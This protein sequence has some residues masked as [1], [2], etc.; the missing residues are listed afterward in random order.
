MLPAM[1]TRPARAAAFASLLLLSLLSC[2]GETARLPQST[3]ADREVLIP[4]PV[5]EAAP[6]PVAPDPAAP[7]PV[8]PDPAAPDPGFTGI[9]G[10]WNLKAAPYPIEASRVE[11]LARGIELID[12][13]VLVLTEIATHERIYDLIR[14]LNRDGTRYYF[15]MPGLGGEPSEQHELGVAFLC[16]SGV[17]ISEAGF[18]P[19]TEL[20]DPTEYRK[21]ITARIRVGEFDFVMV[22][23]HLKSGGTKSGIET[24]GLQCT[25]IAEYLESA[26][27][28]DERDC[29]VTGDFNMIPP[30]EEEDRDLENFKRL[31]A[32]IDLRFL[33][34]PFS[35]QGTHIGYQRKTKTY[36]IH[37]HLDGLAVSKVATQEYEPGSAEIIP[38]FGKME[39]TL[40]EYSRGVSDHLPLVARFDLSQ[41]DD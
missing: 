5:P 12:A 1:F 34:E 19:G 38:L 33:D 20:G 29:I 2:E 6:D 3:A 39:M 32:R 30:T 11:Q 21:A 26:L 8:A 7:G 23:V 17:E 28:G 40:A 36:A 31:N 35:T 41:D 13:D 14:E 16:R 22:G 4:E 18:V 27:M 24:R 9:I 37:N 25:R 15:R 10:T